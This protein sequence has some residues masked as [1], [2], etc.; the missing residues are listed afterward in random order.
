MRS[1]DDFQARALNLL[2]SAEAARAFN[3]EL[4]DPRVRD[5]YGRNSWGQQCLMARRL[6][7]AGVEIIATEFDGPLCGRV[8]NWDD[9]AVNHHVFDANQYRAPFFD[10][11]VSALIEDVYQRGL[12]RRVLVVVAGEFGR[13]PRISYVAS[14]G[15]GIASAPA[16]TV[17]PGRDHWPRA[18]SMLFSG[19]GLRA[20]QVI[21]AT[22]ARGEDPISRRVGPE[23]FL[24]T[25]YHHLGIDIDH[26]MIPDFSGRP[27]P[28]IRN[29][30]PIPEL[31]Q[32]T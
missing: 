6:V 25:L 18:N 29:G 13:T 4:E 30:R 20:G 5:R 19:G 16:G 10:Q 8:A 1:M 26:T 7:E 27:I 17:Q 12:D 3:L 2:T 24:A 9:H 15:G 22:D 28:I 21:G 32:S 23:D 14:S 11:A 31:T